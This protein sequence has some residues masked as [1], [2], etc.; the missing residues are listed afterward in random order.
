MLERLLRVLRVVFFVHLIGGL[1]LLIAL[2]IASP[3]VIGRGRIGSFTTELEAYDFKWW[4]VAFTLVVW[5]VPIILVITWRNAKLAGLEAA[6][7]KA[8]VRELLEGRSFPVIVDV[9]ARIPVRIER[10]LDV[11]FQ[12][13]AKVNIDDQIAIEGSIPLVT[14]LPIDTEISTSVFGLGSVKI[15]IRARIPLNITIPLRTTMH[16]KAAAIPVRLEETAHV[17]LPLL[18][19]PI[20]SRIDARVD[21][22][23]TL[24][25]STR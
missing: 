13:D 1:G 8:H 25:V 10:P 15:P 5:I 18:E 6:K 7:V 12:L 19:V 4:I 3:W 21:I 11:A 9:N 22:L 23:S 24:E 14:E 20:E 17:E 16:V 2:A